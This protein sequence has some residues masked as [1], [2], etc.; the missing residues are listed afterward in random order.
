MNTEDSFSTEMPPSHFESS[1]E[2]SAEQTLR[3][4]GTVV[5]G[6]ENH[7]SHNNGKGY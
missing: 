6:S 7:P 4:N 1:Q 5:G 2:F 3:G